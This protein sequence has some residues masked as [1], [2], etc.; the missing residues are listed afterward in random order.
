MD[1]KDIVR[2]K[3]LVDMISERD[4][5]IINLFQEN[6]RLQ[7]EIERLKNLNKDAK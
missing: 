2:E 1:I 4:Q 3:L 6:Q 5:M 7:Q